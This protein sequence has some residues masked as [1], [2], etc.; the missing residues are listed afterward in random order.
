MNLTCNARTT[1]NTLTGRGIMPPIRKDR[2]P[3]ENRQLH[4]RLFGSERCNCEHC[5]VYRTAALQAGEDLVGEASKQQERRNAS[6]NALGMLKKLLATLHKE[7][8]PECYS[9]EDNAAQSDDDDGRADGKHMVCD[10]CRG[11]GL[12]CSEGPICDQCQMSGTPCIHRLCPGSPDSKD[13]CSHPTCR[14]VHRDYLPTP[15]F[16]TVADYIILP[17]ELRQYQVD[18][19]IR[20]HRWS[21]FQ[22]D[23]PAWEVFEARMKQRQVSALDRAE[24]YVEKGKGTLKTFHGGCGAM[25]G[26][27]PAL[28]EKKERKMDRRE[29]WLG[30]RADLRMIVREETEAALERKLSKEEWFKWALEQSGDSDDEESEDDASQ[31]S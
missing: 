28:E 20:W 23:Q 21:D 4:R 29:E 1:Y 26:S 7:H 2:S 25:C 3:K 9:S 6:S 19:D 24:L 13:D 8:K 12:C 22:M 30:S 16:C 15:D 11:H 17:G 18:G 14:Y 31:S 10:H 27:S 5:T